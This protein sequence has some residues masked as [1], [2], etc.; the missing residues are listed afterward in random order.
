MSLLLIIIHLLLI[1]LKVL[2]HGIACVSR[3]RTS[4]RMPR[5]HWLRGIEGRGI[6]RA[7]MSVGR[8]E[9]GPREASDSHRGRGGFTENILTLTRSWFVP[10]YRR[11]PNEEAARPFRRLFPHRGIKKARRRAKRHGRRRAR[12]GA[13]ARGCGRR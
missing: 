1:P 13:S 2:H 8:T 5:C 12:A 7:Y 6:G 4:T 11:S 9:E 3:A 10:V